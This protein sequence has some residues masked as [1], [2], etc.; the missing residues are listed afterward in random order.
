MK[1][2]YIKEFIEKEQIQNRIM[3]QRAMNLKNQKGITLLV[4]V[5]TIIILLILAGITIGTLTGDNGIIQNAGEAK[6]ETEIA[7]EKEILEK[8]TV[9]AMGNNK[10]G[11]IE[12][13]ELQE[14]LD[15]ETGEGKTEATDIGDE[16][17]VVF[18]DSNRYYTVDKDGNIGEVQKIVKDEYPGNITVGTD[19]K[20]LAGDATEP[21]EI[22]CIEDLV[23]WSQNYSNYLNNC[24]NLGRTLNFKSNLS[25]V[26][27]K[28]LGCNSVE[29]LKDLLTNTTDSGFTPIANFS[30]TF[31]GK[32]YEIQNIYINTEE[33]AGLFS[34]ATGKIENV[35]ISGNITSTEK[36]AGGIV[37][38]D[39]D[40]TINLEVNECEN[41]AK[42]V[43]L[44][45]AGGG[46][47]GNGNGIQ[48]TNCY[49]YGEIYSYGTERPSTNYEIGCA[50][51]IVGTNCADIQDCVNEGN[52]SS[53]ITA[54]GIIGYRYMDFNIVNCYNTGE[55]NGTTYSG[56]IIG[57]T[58]A[59]IGNIY[60][61]YNLGSIYSDT[62][63]GGIAGW[64]YYNTTAHIYNC[65][66]IGTI[67]GK[68]NVGGI[69]GRSGAG[70]GS[71]TQY[72][73]IIRNTYSMPSTL[74]GIG[75]FSTSEVI[76]NETNIENVINSLNEY[77]NNTEDGINKNS[78]KKWG[79]D[80]NNKI[81]FISVIK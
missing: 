68:Q 66:N 16:F 57:E 40:T 4:L 23:E 21:Y 18:T 44:R 36:N 46:I 3:I 49:N 41:K 17:E 74:K 58:K 15:E 55:I 73:P 35:K 62:N 64:I 7:N 9:Q 6:E 20:E 50:G 24:I 39:V 30:S 75:N 65:C 63:S 13:S 43:S 14:Q 78:W 26:D 38:G 11:N 37:A 51:G 60:N 31:N 42:V 12:E 1:E 10:Y 33:N 34:K 79:I 45:K 48:I 53:T 19:G 27:G 25:Y 5:V 59:G 76:T 67:T 70:S 80:E 52:V 77:I 2:K 28:I 47:A 54:G 71:Y 29:E 8:A 22:Y 32:G 69:I 61:C 81:C 72:M 56:G